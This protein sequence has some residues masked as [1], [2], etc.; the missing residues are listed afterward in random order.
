MAK[1][2]KEVGAPPKGN[3]RPPDLGEFVSKE[4]FNSKFDSLQG[5]MGKMLDMMEKTSTP[6][7]PAQVEAKAVEE[8]KYD[9]Q[10]AINPSWEAAAREALGVKLDHCEVNY[11]KEGGLQFTIVIKKEHS[12]AP[13]D[14]LERYKS[15]RRTKEVGKTG[16][17]GVVEWIKRVN[18]N[19]N[20]KKY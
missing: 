6:G 15:D 7:N 9:T 18:Q 13:K 10:A 1:K 5:A 11:P 19:L 14:Y 17:E 12:N 8:A 2:D 4:E 3:G 16:Y 20:T